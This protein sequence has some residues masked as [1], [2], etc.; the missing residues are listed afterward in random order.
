[1]QLQWRIADL[2]H[3]LSHRQEVS[4]DVRICLL[5]IMNN[6]YQYLQS[7]V[8]HSHRHDLIRSWNKSE[9]Q[10]AG[11]ITVPASHMTELR[12]REFKS[13]PQSPI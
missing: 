13:Y 2:I 7:P 12:L 9:V 6:N 4:P 11:S 10:R 3:L 5:F 1:M 8:K